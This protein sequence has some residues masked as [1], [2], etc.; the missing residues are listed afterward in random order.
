MAFCCI[1][2]SKRLLTTEPFLR[3][4]YRI[5]KVFSQSRNL[6]F[7]IRE[8]TI[9]HSKQSSLL[10]TVAFLHTISGQFLSIR[11][12]Y[13]SRHKVEQPPRA[14]ASA[15][16]NKLNGNARQLAYLGADLFKLWS[17][18]HGAVLDHVYQTVPFFRSAQRA[19]NY[20]ILSNQ[21]YQLIALDQILQKLLFVRSNFQKEK[22]MIFLI[23]C[24]TYFV[25]RFKRGG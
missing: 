6:Q 8:W 20:R 4:L 22:I 25:A 5:Q 12:E 23:F 24:N 2:T 9:F 17:C 21:W 1:S 10:V 19:F 13:S 14:S 18:Y 16:A 3:M 7:L 11:F 15:P